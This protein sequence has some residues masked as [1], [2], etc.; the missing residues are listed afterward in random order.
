[1][2]AFLPLLTVLGCT[3]WMGDTEVAH[4]DASIEAEVVQ[5]HYRYLGFSGTK[6]LFLPYLGCESRLVLDVEG[7]EVEVQRWEGKVGLPLIMRCPKGARPALVASPDGT[8]VAVNHQGWTIYQRTGQGLFPAEV[9]PDFTGEPHQWGSLRDVRMDPVALLRDPTRDADVEQVVEMVRALPSAERRAFLDAA[10]PAEGRRRVLPQW[11]WVELFSELAEEDQEGLRADLSGRLQALMA[12]APPGQ[13][14]SKP[15]SELWALLSP[16]VRVPE[17][18]PLFVAAAE[19]A[20]FGSDAH[21]QD[22]YAALWPFEPEL[23]AEQACAALTT[24]DRSQASLLVFLQDTEPTCAAADALADT[25]E[26]CCDE[27]CAWPIPAPAPAELL[28]ETLDGPASPP[29]PTA[30]LRAYRAAR[31]TYPRHFDQ[32][33]GRL[34]YRVEQD[35]PD[36]VGVY[37]AGIRC[38]APPDRMQERACR[39]PGADAMTDGEL[40]FEVDD[41]EGR[42]HRVQSTGDRPLT[43]TVKPGTGGGYDCVQSGPDPFYG[44]LRTRAV[45][46]QV[47]GE[48]VEVEPTHLP[49]ERAP[50]GVTLVCE[51]TITRQSIPTLREAIAEWGLKTEDRHFTSS[52]LVVPASPAG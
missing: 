38:A 33:H 35:G 28:Q 51:L 36:C 46:W 6:V 41:A 9:P 2:Q 16:M 39:H 27:D 45:T 52:P 34:G 10:A 17:D 13:A 8:F 11:L 25:L 29:D 12:A 48:G 49:F 24:Q 43:V 23:V 26:P 20:A 5:S 7:V 22:V 15:E 14:L 18:L 50:P 47:N 42:I 31:G 3:P 40:R 21:R 32:A 44:L 4:L 19:R 1:M 37:E 30:F